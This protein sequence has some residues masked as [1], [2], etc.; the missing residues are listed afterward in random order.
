[1]HLLDEGFCLLRVCGCDNIFS[2]DGMPDV[3]MLR[4]GLSSDQ[5]PALNLCDAVN[6][7]VKLKWRMTLLC[8]TRQQFKVLFLQT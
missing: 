1:M 6:F 7:P 2:G 5:T 3:V 8:N 4:S